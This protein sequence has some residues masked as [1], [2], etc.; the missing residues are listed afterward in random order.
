MQFLKYTWYLTST[1]TI[2]LIRDGKKGL[3]RWGQR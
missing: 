3:W 1:K 2:R